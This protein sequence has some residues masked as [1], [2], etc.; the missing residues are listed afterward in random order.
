MLFRKKVLKF[1]YAY[2]VRVYFKKG[3]KHGKIYNNNNNNN[4]NE[5]ISST[6]MIYMASRLK[7]RKTIM[8]MC[9]YAVEKYI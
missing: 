6:S 2:N 4:N 5:F 9:N 1:L 7:M 8:Y 3:G